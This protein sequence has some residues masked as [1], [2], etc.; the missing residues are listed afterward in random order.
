MAREIELKIRLADPASLRLILA[1]E[2][3]DLGPYFKEDTYFRGPGTAFRLRRETGRLVVCLKQKT[4]SSGIESSREIEFEIG[5]A[6]EFRRFAEALGYQEWY[7]KRKTG[8]AWKY[9]DILIEEG[10]VSGLGWFAE[11]EILLDEASDAHAVEAARARLR[12]ALQRLGVDAAAIEPR[13]YSQLL[14]HKE[15]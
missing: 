13:T 12:D 2:A 11:F 7:A 9:R 1:R 14:G 15:S 4:I 8:R 6:E 3:E 10:E 5:A